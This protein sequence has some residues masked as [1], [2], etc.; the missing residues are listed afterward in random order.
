MYLKFHFDMDKQK[1]NK[2]VWS[3]A[4]A[5]GK[6]CTSCDVESCVDKKKQNSNVS[7]YYHP[8]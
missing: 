2:K 7:S 6:N 5:K 3:R 4:L 8:V 1:V